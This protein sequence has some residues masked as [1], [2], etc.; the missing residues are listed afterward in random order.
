M[1]KAT[2]RS[3]YKRPFGDALRGA[4]YF[5]LA[6]E[7]RSGSTDRH[8]TSHDSDNQFK[9]PL[10]DRHCNL[11]AKCRPLNSKVL[12]SSGNGCRIMSWAWLA[13]LQSDNNR[14]R[15]LIRAC[16]LETTVL[17]SLQLER[18][19]MGFMNMGMGATGAVDVKDLRTR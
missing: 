17:S 1:H 18:K 16:W 3:S 2:G 5:H 6:S 4:H 11:N 8:F 14:T 10:D 12:T 13:T 15:K 9:A 7:T 19:G